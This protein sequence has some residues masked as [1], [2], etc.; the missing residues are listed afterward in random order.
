MVWCGV[1]NG[2]HPSNECPRLRARPPTSWCAHC[3]RWGNHETH[4]CQYPSIAPLPQLYQPKNPLALPPPT[5]HIVQ[6]PNPIHTI[7]SSY[8]PQ[9][10]PLPPSVLG[11]QPPPPRI[12]PMNQVVAKVG[13][14]EWVEQEL[15]IEEPNCS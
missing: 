3:N 4:Q 15:L 14:L 12:T 9:H 5:G 8:H 2:N 13:T 6:Q 11:P 1:C 10:I 7:Q